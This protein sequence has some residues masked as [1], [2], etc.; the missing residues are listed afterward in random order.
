MSARIKEGTLKRFITTNG[1]EVAKEHGI[2]AAA[3]ASGLSR[4]TVYAILQE[5]KKQPTLRPLIDEEQWQECEGAKLFL[6]KHRNRIKT[7][8]KSY[9]TGFVSWLLL[10]KKEPAKWT[11]DD[12]RKLWNYEGFIDSVTK[13]IRDTEAFS[14]R[15]WM[16]TFEKNDIIKLEEFSRRGLKRP[17]S[18]KTWFLEDKDFIELIKKTQRHDLLEF[19]DV[20]FNSGGRAGSVLGVRPL[21][22]NFEKNIILMF[23]SKI[24]DYLPRFINEGCMR[25]LKK[26]IQDYN[27]A[28][29]KPLFPS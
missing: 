22:C 19:E 27:V 6:A 4:P 18:R 20:G 13:R 26:Y 23:E 2:T 29:D 21:D 28:P 14:L 8:K 25:R 7:W 11:L 17:K 15:L 10:G 12:Y 16:R 24:N 1:F 9:R 3:R 5:Y